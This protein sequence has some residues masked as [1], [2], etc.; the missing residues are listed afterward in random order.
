MWYYPDCSGG[1]QHRQPVRD[2]R[3]RL[4]P[5]FTVDGELH[6]RNRRIPVTDFRTRGR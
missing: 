1:G 3:R 2:V 5:G 4:E 6:H